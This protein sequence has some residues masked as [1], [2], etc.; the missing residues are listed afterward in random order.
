[1]EHAIRKELASGGG[2][3]RAGPERKRKIGLRRGNATR[4][5]KKVYPYHPHRIFPG[6]IPVVLKSHVTK[7]FSH[8]F[9]LYSF[10]RYNESFDK[11][12]HLYHRTR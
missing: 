7:T 12:V 5:C 11:P 3:D 6:S 4:I 1:M 2:A 9:P 10:D 8:G